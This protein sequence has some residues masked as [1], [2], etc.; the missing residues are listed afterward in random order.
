MTSEDAKEV[1][2]AAGT[3]RADKVKAEKAAAAAKKGGEQQTGWQLARLAGNGRKEVDICFAR[4]GATTALRDWEKLNLAQ[5][6]HR[7]K[8][9]QVSTSTGSR[10]AYLGIAWRSAGFGWAQA[11]VQNHLSEV[12]TR[13]ICTNRLGL[14]IKLRCLLLHSQVVQKKSCIM[15]MGFLA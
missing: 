2:N 11:W 15:R 1:E 6:G 7:A 13:L 5:A 14:G 3:I 8:D 9:V 12:S 10:T 4:V